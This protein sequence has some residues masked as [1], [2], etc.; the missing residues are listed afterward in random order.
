MR[1]SYH[2][3]KGDLPCEEDAYR[4]L[5]TVLCQPPLRDYG[6]PK[7]SSRSRMIRAPNERDG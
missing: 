3:P 6:R 5:Y 7:K 4:K 1:G 2:L